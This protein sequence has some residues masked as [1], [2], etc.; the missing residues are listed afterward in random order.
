MKRERLL[1]AS[2][3]AYVSSTW[4]RRERA[5]A[6]SW[7]RSS[8]RWSD[9][10]VDTTATGRWPKK[11]CG[12]CRVPVEGN[13]WESRWRARRR[14]QR[15]DGPA[16]KCQARHLDRLLRFAACRSECPMESFV[17][18]PTRCRIV[19]YMEVLVRS[20]E[21][22]WSL[23]DLHNASPNLYLARVRRYPKRR[24]RWQNLSPCS[25]PRD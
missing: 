19:L 13:S 25:L 9:M 2:T 14:Q 4:G 6:R 11:I 17:L 7:P 20:A 21:A 22:R 16:A 5:R 23:Y 3:L 1:V 18:L 15:V 24:T 8:A 12:V 10:D